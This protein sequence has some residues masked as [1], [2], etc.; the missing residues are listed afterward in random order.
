[1]TQM[2]GHMLNEF[3]EEVVTTRR[4]IDRLHADKLSW[5]PHPES[6]SLGQLAIHIASV[7]GSV[8]RIT[9]ANEFDVAQGSF[10]PPQPKNVEEVRSAFDQSVREVE[11]YLSG[12]TD[13]TARG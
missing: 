8:A 1:M 2:L 6:M 12:M 13:Q 7:P 11:E 10:V 9:R 5:R 4:F 3:R